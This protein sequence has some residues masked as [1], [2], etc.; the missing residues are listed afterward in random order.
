MR[1]RV[2]SILLFVLCLVVNAQQ[3]ASLRYEDAL[4]FRMINQCFT[5]RT[6]TPYT[7]YDA[8]LEDSVNSGFWHTGTNSAGLGIRFSTNSTAVGLR[9]NLRDNF[10]MVH[11]A[12]TGTKGADLYILDNGRWRYVNTSRPQ[13]RDSVQNRLLVENLDGEEHEFLVYL[14]LYDGINWMEIGVDSA[15]WLDAPHVDNPQTD[16]KIVFYGTSI[17]QGGCASRTGMVATSMIQRELGLECCNMAI[18][19]Q[20]RMWMPVARALASEPNVVAYVLDP[21]PNCPLRM[22][23]SIG[24]E[25]VSTFR[26]LN[27]SAAIV[28]VEIAPVPSSRYDTK[29]RDSHKQINAAYRA[30]YDRLVREG[31]KNIYFV[32]SDGLTGPEE[33]G[34]VDGNHLTDYGFRAYADKLIS[35][36]RPILKKQKTAKNQH[37]NK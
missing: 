22:V 10:H 2:L 36:L 30:I 29:T 8:V 35:V 11:M 19:G 14:P 21:L 9:Y 17:L 6:L 34:T 1:I 31:E 7:R 5:G 37:N 24:Y 27:P 18:S 12:D 20:G 23:D 32:T 13:P 28:M 16:R 4:R 26:R 33:E 25:W 3:K 15:A